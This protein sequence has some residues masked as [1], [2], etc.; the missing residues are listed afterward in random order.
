MKKKRQEQ[1]KSDKKI[2]GRKRLCYSIATLAVVVAL[3]AG[4]S[5]AWFVQDMNMATLMEVRSPSDIAIL[6][7]DAKEM[8]SLDLD[9]TDKDKNGDTVTVRRVICVQS[10]SDAHRLEIVHTTNMK[11]LTFK[12]YP[13]TVQNTSS[14]TGSSGEEMGDADT[15]TGTVTASGTVTDNGYTFSY[16]PSKVVEGSY[17]NLSGSSTDNYKY[18]NDSKHATNYN[19][20]S[21]VQAHAEPVYWLTTDALEAD[22]T[23][24]VDVEGTTGTEKI[25]NHR[26]YYVCEVTWTESTKETDI[27]YI[28]AET[29]SQTGTNT[30]TGSEAN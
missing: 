13:A 26:T 1:E 22:K 12:L 15:S 29:A 4:F 10:A 11:G 17:I 27:F 30:G 23:N 18:A 21:N 28:L 7:P 6:G 3:F 19:T 14:G 5:R 9:Y 8:V 16:D 25:K 20:Y 24:D 2:S